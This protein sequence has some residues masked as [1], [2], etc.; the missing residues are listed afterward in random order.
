MT[1]LNLSGKQSTNSK[2]DPSANSEEGSIANQTVGAL[3]ALAMFAVVIVVG[4]CSRSSKPVAAQQTVQPAAPVSAPAVAAP[5]PAPVVAKSKTKTRRAPVLAYVNREYGVAFSF[6]RQYVLKAGMKAQS[7][8]SELALFEM[9]FAQPGGITLAAVE[10]P[11]SS[12][13][14]TDF[15]SALVNVSVNPGMSAESCH[16]FAS[17]DA[18]PKA[19]S[20]PETA[21]SESPKMVKIG[22]TEF[23][24]VEN[25][26]AAMTNQTA[27]NQTDARYYH[28]FNNGSCYE[29]ALGVGTEGDG[30]VEGAKAVDRAAVF[31]KLEKI[32][33]SAKL[34]A[35]SIPKT[36]TAVPTAKAGASDDTSSTDASNAEA[37][38]CD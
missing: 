27:M 13:P 12:Y 19:D 2:Q 34:Q 25:S 36:E 38:D 1:Q 5:A 9:D 23:S 31:G 14:G 16:Q 26:T 10:I 11:K 7:S 24:E 35:V 8:W 4:S 18:N 28:A 37:P 22:G 6:P 20:S 32:L 21:K 17:P 3:G 29:F 15:K 33:A 30:S